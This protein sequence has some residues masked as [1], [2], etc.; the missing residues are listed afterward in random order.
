MN[1]NNKCAKNKF[2]FLLSLST[3]A[4]ALSVVNEGC[5]T[6]YVMVSNILIK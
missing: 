3:A 6:D 2:V 4:I 5:S 1:L